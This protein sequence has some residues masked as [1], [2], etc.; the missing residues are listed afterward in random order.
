M[1]QYDLAIAYRVYPGISKSPAFY[2][3]DKLALAE[4]G[5]RSLRL[6]LGDLRTRLYAI[7]DGCPPEYE[8]LVLRYFP[9]EHTEI[10]HRQRAGNAAT[11]IE[12]LDYLLEQPHAKFVYFAE[13]DYL[14]RPGTLPRL[15][16]FAEQHRDAHFLA[17]YDYPDYYQMPLHR[18]CLQMRY[19]AG[20][21]WRS[22]GTACLTFLT[23]RSILRRTHTLWRT[24]AKGNFDASMWMALTKHAVFHPLRTVRSSI[25]AAIMAKAWYYG[26]RRILFGKRWMLWVPIPSMA[27]HLER[28]TLA[29]GVDWEAVRQEVEAAYA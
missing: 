13:D 5:L 1:M 18:G 23:R 7:L 26:W 10:V 3:T 11:F 8:A 20:Y 15:L 2:S 9:A 29:P 16:T 21:H 25:E 22:A 4:L 24:Y 19:A 17:P 28:T 6:A 14:Y 27:T 12:Q